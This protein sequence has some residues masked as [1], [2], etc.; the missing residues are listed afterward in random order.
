MFNLKNKTYAYP[1]HTVTTS[2]FH[3]AGFFP[4][5]EDSGLHGESQP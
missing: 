1:D 5:Y 2:L 3:F 4:Y